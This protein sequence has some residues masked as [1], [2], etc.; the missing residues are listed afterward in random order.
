MF[1][2]CFIFQ[3]NLQTNIAK[4]N[5][6]TNRNDALSRG[7]YIEFDLFSLRCNFF[8]YIYIY[9]YHFLQFSPLSYSMIASGVFLN[10]Y[11]WM[12]IWT[13]FSINYVVYDIFH[14]Y[15]YHVG[16]NRGWVGLC[17]MGYEL[18]TYLIQLWKIWK[19]NSVSRKVFTTYTTDCTSNDSSCYDE[20][21]SFVT[22]MN[23]RPDF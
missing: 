14:L 4:N 19:C 23:I 6:V 7:W 20:F 18:A 10:F 9:I 11:P 22:L 21:Y 5:K 16:I 2:V 17:W 15:I 12:I 13:N 1:F 8:I 3:L